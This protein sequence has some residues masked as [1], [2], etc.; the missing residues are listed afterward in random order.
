[1]RAFRQGCSRVCSLMP[2]RANPV[3]RGML[4][5]MTTIDD[6]RAAAERIRGHVH[7]TPTTTETSLGAMFGV[8]LAVKAELFQRTG[9][10]KIRGVLNRV[11]ALP[12]GDRDRG[13]VTMSAGNHAAALAYAARLVGTTAVVVMPAHANPGKIAATESYGGEV[14]LTA[15]SLHD[16]MTEI[17]ERTGRTLVHPFD[18]P[19]VIAGA[20]TVGLE[21]VEDV[22]DV[23]VVIVP[24]GGGGLIAGVATAVKAL[25]PTALVYGVEPETADGVSQGLAQGEPVH[26]TPTSVADALCAPF[27][28]VHPLPLIREH[29]ERVVTVDD[30]TI[31]DALR[32]FLQRT[33]LA[34]EPAGATGLAALLA[35][36]VEPKTDANVVLVASGGNIDAATLARLLAS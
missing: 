3:I 32:L 20:G 18:D 34:V 8:R 17:K 36:A 23:D 28:G 30:A 1:M 29:V 21:I 2:S 35:R 22:P 12:D 13:L 25:R 11:L 7:R 4:S 19:A 5:R 15:G 27:A 16:T 6:V 10:F 24:V 14:V 33:K 31:L 26:I 9:S